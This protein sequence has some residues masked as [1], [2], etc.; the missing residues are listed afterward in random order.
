[1]LCRLNRFVP[2]PLGRRRE[3]FDH[4]DWLFE[5][6]YDGFRTLAHVTGGGSK[7][8]LGATATRSKAAL[9]GESCF[10]AAIVL[11][12]IH[13]GVEGD[14]LVEWGDAEEPPCFCVPTPSIT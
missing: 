4:P 9:L 2:M 1:M 12:C 8:R 11:A 7:L 14:S 13:C 10:Y 3:P 5:L 6:K